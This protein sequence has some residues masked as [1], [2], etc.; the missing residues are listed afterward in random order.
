MSQKA[1]PHLPISHIGINSYPSMFDCTYKSTYRLIFRYI[2][3][4][5]VFSS[6]HE[7]KFSTV[8]VSFN[9]C[10]V[11]TNAIYFFLLEPLSCF[12]ASLFD[13]SAI[14]RRFLFTVLPSSST[15]KNFFLLEIANLHYN[16]LLVA[17]FE[18]V[19]TGLVCSGTNRGCYLLVIREHKLCYLLCTSS[20]FWYA[21]CILSASDENILLFR[22]TLS[23][24]YWNYLW[25]LFIVSTIFI[26]FHSKNLAVYVVKVDDL[27][28]VSTC[29]RAHSCP[30]SI[31]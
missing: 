1:L 10:E 28:V 25:G 26:F 24:G 13:Y 23:H 21:L 18:H 27:K 17:M 4:G 22:G 15:W 19:A 11:H 31:V 12:E 20:Y 5:C 14:F 6:P 30:V 9:L 16:Q 29:L 2:L 8:R 7:W 3:T